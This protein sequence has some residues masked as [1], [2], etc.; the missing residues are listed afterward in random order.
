MDSTPD[1]TTTGGPSGTTSSN[2]STDISNEAFKMTKLKEN[3]R[4]CSS[5][6]NFTN[7]EFRIYRFLKL[8]FIM[9]YFPTGKQRKKN[10]FGPIRSLF[11]FLTFPACF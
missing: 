3:Q 8:I 10:C 7:L 6:D 5:S 4:R 11:S 2:N 1:S 9:I